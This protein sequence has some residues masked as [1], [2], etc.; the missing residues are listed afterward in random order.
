[1]FVTNFPGLFVLGIR[2]VFFMILVS[3]V[4]WYVV[5]V[6]FVVGAHAHAFICH[7]LYEEPHF[8]TLT[9]LMDQSGMIYPEG[10]VLTNLLHPG[11]DVHLG[12]GHVLR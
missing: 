11:R 6:V 7:P 10:P 5:V 3:G 12:M 9:H 2:S 1:M 4:L 8:P